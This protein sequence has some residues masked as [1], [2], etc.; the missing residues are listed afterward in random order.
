V[1]SL[2]GLLV[3]VATTS[4]VAALVPQQR[5]TPC[6]AAWDVGNAKATLGARPKQPWDAVCSDGDP[7]CD[8]DGEENG[9]CR[10]AVAACAAVATEGCMP[11]TIRKV[12]IP[13]ATRKKVPGLA[14]PPART[15]GAAILQRSSRR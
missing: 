13:R 7:R 3:L 11:A 8:L 5:G 15:A 6:D 14:R 10:V 1:R 12:V 2:V 4:S 9:E